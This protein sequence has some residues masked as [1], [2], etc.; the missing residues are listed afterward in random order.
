[1]LVIALGLAI[2]VIVYA[3][4]A[5]IWSNGDGGWFAYAPNTGVVFSPE[6]GAGLPGRSTDIVR[7]GA[8][9]LG[10]VV[11]WGRISYWILRRRDS[12]A[13]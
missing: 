13:G 4:D 6:T 7:S 3:W 11:V 1:M 12:D 9:W 10:G 2:A 8:M 5:M